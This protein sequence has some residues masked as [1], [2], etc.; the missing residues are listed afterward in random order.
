MPLMWFRGWAPKDVVPWLLP[1]SS[2]RPPRSSTYL[3][4]LPLS[5]ATGP[6]LPKCRAYREHLPFGLDLS[7][8]SDDNYQYTLEPVTTFGPVQQ[9]QMIDDT[10]LAVCVPHHFRTGETVWVNICKR[11]P[12]RAGWTWFCEWVS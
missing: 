4:S 8:V 7:G 10:F 1:D 2:L 5:S 6:N 12:D 3:R 11:R 9:V